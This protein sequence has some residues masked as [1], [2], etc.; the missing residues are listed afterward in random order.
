MSVMSREEFLRE[1]A[2]CA[3]REPEIDLPREI[4]DE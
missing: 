3:G 1:F 4:L 2:R